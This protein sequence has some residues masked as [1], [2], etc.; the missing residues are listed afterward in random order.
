MISLDTSRCKK[1][2]RCIRLMK[3][4]CIAEKYGYPVFDYSVCNECQ[5]CVSICPSMA[6]M[7]NNTYPEKISDPGKLLS[8]EEL[9]SLMERRRSIKHFKD[10]R[11]PKKVLLKIISSAG[12]APNQNK[13]IAI[14]VIDDKDLIGEIDK[15]ALSLVRKVY[16]FLFSLPPLTL[17]FKLFAGNLNALKRKMER[18]LFRKK[19]IVKEN[20]QAVIVLTGPRRVPV[21]ERSAPY[22]LSAMI[23]MAQTLGVGSCLMDSLVHTLNMSR[24]L[25]RIL[26]IK[27]N[28]LGVL[29]LGYSSENILN[30]PRGYKLSTRWNTGG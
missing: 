13:N 29:V 7:V 14:I 20:T 15:S 21:T 23:Y 9:A 22:L 6:I 4:Y 10:K 27:D 19:H 1:C 8:P 11:I 26:H 16:S 30:I 3:N 28:I 12:Y 24:K 18:D 25:K 17:F 5:K 2:G